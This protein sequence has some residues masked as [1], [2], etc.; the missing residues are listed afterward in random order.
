MKAIRDV[1]VI[2][3]VVMLLLRVP[4]CHPVGQSL[5]NDS[6]LMAFPA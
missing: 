3:M 4:N 1:V 5:S 2:V 6:T